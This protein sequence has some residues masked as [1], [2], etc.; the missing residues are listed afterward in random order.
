MIGTGRESEI[1]ERGLPLRA[2]A[3]RSVK[4]RDSF[5]HTLGRFRARNEL[6]GITGMLVEHGP[7]VAQYVEGQGPEVE[8]L[9]RAVQADAR[10]TDVELVADVAP[11]G[12]L[13]PG[14]PLAFAVAR[15]GRR[16]G[17]PATVC[18]PGLEATAGEWTRIAWPPLGEPVPIDGLFGGVDAV[19]DQWSRLAE[20]THE[21]DSIRALLTEAI[22]GF[23]DDLWQLARKLR[24]RGISSESIFLELIEPATRAL[25]DRWLADRIPQLDVTVAMGALQLLVRRLGPDFRRR[26]AEP[27][28]LSALVAS[29]PGEPHLVDLGLISEFF[30][31]DG[32]EVACLLPS[33]EAELT[34]EVGA[35]HFDVLA[36]C[37]SS[38]FERP[39]RHQA[40]ARHVAAARRASRNADLIVLASGRDFHTHPELGEALGADASLRSAADATSVTR[41]LLRRKE[42]VKEPPARSLRELVEAVLARIRA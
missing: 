4:R 37:S 11:K 12:R 26:G 41:A 30:E 23:P 39:E 19:M 13:F 28:P 2:I 14:R 29:P 38:A 1:P 24:R 22:R 17:E 18:P 32:W 9:W 42:G 40:F 3:Y 15:H 35:R 6:R 5:E 27:H 34:E 33:S 21:S 16:A 31:R 8:R 20:R 25:G 7:H 36:L 10:H